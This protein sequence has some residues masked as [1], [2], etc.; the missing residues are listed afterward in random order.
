MPKSARKPAKKRDG[1]AVRKPK[2]SQQP[3]AAKGAKPSGGTAADTT[4]RLGS[5]EAIIAL[6]GKLTRLEKD[7]AGVSGDFSQAWENHEKINIHKGALQDARRIGKMRDPALAKYW[8]HL[9]HCFD[10]LGIEDRATKQLD[11][12]KKS[13]AKDKKAAD[14]KRAAADGE[15]GLDDVG[16]IRKKIA[17]GEFVS[18]DEREKLA[19]F[20]PPS[21]IERVGRG[22]A[23]A[24]PAADNT[25]LN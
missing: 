3:A 23:A 8:A 24:K 15:V 6:D 25:K 13:V 2:K 10:V 14:E 21:P 22:P 4:I 16:K 20:D 12:F 7:R 9:M 18:Q 1:K 11:M 17:A 19:E 5:P